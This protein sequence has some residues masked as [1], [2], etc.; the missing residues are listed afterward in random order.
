M[1]VFF[2]SNKNGWKTHPKSGLSFQKLRK[3]DTGRQTRANTVSFKVC[4]FFFILCFFSALPRT[5]WIFF[6]HKT[7]NIFSAALWRVILLILFRGFFY[8]F[9][10]KNPPGIPYFS[11]EKP[12]MKNR[13]AQLL[14]SRIINWMKFKLRD[15]LSYAMHVQGYCISL[16]YTRKVCTPV[17]IR[18]FLL[19]NTYCCLLMHVP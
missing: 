11:I 12:P 19:M 15:Q 17:Y 18:H 16:A 10:K 8:R 3:E 5:F 2:F 14:E 4:V 13:M 7:W 9:P 1:N 6:W